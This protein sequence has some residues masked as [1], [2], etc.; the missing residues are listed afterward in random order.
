MG[1]SDKKPKIALIWPYPPPKRWHFR[2]Y[3]KV[4]RELEKR[5]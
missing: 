1:K 3:T 4:K 5:V 2:A